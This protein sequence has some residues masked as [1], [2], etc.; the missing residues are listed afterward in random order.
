MNHTVY[1][2]DLDGTLLTNKAVLSDFSRN[3]LQKLLRDGLPFTVASARSVVSMCRVL[4]DLDL[5]LPIVEF[6]GA[7][8]SDL[9]SGRH[10]IINS[11]EPS[12]VEDIYQLISSFNCVPFIS[13]FNGSQDCVYYKDILNEG[14]HWYLKESLSNK[15]QKT[16]PKTAQVSL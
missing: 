2:S 12:V 15:D 8:I 13:S 7:F 4:G 9:K 6:N 14:M 16:S 5:P 11:I 3:T 1:I 10:E